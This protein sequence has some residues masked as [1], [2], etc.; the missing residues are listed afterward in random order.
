MQIFLSSSLATAILLSA[1]SSSLMCSA[2]FDHVYS[3]S[4]ITFH[5][6]FL[7]HKGTKARSNTKYVRNDFVNLR[8]PACRQAG[9]GLSGSKFLIMKV[10]T[11]RWVDRW[12]GV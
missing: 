3:F 7:N 2:I 8:A 10:S 11:M 12:I 9:S 4:C 6:L 1:N 5:R